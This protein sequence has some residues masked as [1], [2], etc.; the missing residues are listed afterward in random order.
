MPG[1]FKRLLAPLAKS[2]WSAS[3]RAYQAELAKRPRLDDDQ[4]FEKFYAGTGVPKAIPIRLRKLLCQRIIGDD[5]SALYPEDNIALIYDGLDFADVLYRVEREFDVAIPRATWKTGENLGGEIDGTFG[6]VV[7]YLSKALE[8]RDLEKQFAP[9]AVPRR[10]AWQ[11]RLGALAT[12]GTLA[13]AIPALAGFAGRV[14]WVFELMSHFRAQYF[15]ALSVGTILLLAAGCR[16]RALLAGALVAVHA[17][18]LGPFYFAAS[19]PAARADASRLRLVSSNL[20]A[21]NE[22]HQKVLDLVRRENPDVAVFLEVN[23]RWGKAL[24]SLGDEWPYSRVVAQ[25]G[26]FGIAMCSRLPFE[27]CRVESLSEGYPAIIARFQIGGTPLTL[28]AA[29]PV[30]PVSARVSAGRNRQLAELAR[31]VTAA[32]GEK[33]VVGDMNTTSWSPFFA[34][35]LAKTGLAD[36]RRGRGIQPSW[37]ADLPIFTRIPI[38]HCLA[39]KGLRATR[40]EIGPDVGSDHLPVIVELEV[41]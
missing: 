27:E 13:V 26:N 38:D 15:V 5:L 8:G 32:S 22:E 30:P 24:E 41:P 6:S 7:R 11:E 28:F 16:R 9:S 14:W 12:L 4:F 34:D 31:L 2:V 20:H 40:R 33:I 1:F 25:P 17:A 3:E 18:M 10:A 35:F 29:H 36:T 23:E 19:P 21:V 37:R 39:S